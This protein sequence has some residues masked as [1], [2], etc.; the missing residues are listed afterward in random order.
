MRTPGQIR[1]TLAALGAAQIQ[2]VRRG[3]VVEATCRRPP[4]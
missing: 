4:C 1:R 3:Y 2:V